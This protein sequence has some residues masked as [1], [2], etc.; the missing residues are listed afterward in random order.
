MSNPISN[1]PDGTWEGDPRAPWNAPDDPECETCYSQ[2]STDWEYCPF[3]GEH[4]D[5]EA[6]E[7]RNEVH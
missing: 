5:W 1:Y 6:R 7:Y 2:L 3:C 4:I